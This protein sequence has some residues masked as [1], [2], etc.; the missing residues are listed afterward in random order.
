[1]SVI[2]NIKLNWNSDQHFGDIFGIYVM[3]D[4]WSLESHNFHITMKVS[5]YI[6]YRFWKKINKYESFIESLVLLFS[7]F[8]LFYYVYVCIY[9]YAYL[10]V[11]SYEY[12]LLALFM[13]ELWLSVFLL[14]VGE[15][16]RN[17]FRTWVK[18][19]R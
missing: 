13:L 6:K 10:H 18:G 15:M 8:T 3:L 11:Y 9:S 14:R 5:T 16:T 12:I 19:N 1:M 2:L 7:F 4:R 17:V